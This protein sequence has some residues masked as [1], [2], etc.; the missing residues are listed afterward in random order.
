MRSHP[1]PIILLLLLFASCGRIIAQGR[2]LTPDRVN[3]RVQAAAVEILINGRLSGS[4]AVIDRSGIVVTAA[5]VVANPNARIEI[6][7]PDNQKLTAKIH[8]K[9]AGHDVI[10][11]TLPKQSGGYVALQPA[12]RTVTVGSK[13]FMVA[14]PLFRHRQLFTGT[15]TQA[16]ASAEFL[17]PQ[18]VEVFYIQT[19]SPHGTSGAAWVNSQGQYIG[20]QSAMLWVKNAPQG[21][22]FAA[23]LSAIEDLLENPRIVG[24][25]SAGFAVEELWEQSPEFLATVPPELSG[26]VIRFL[27]K[28]SPF[29]QAKIPTGTI[30]THI[31]TKALNTRD[32]FVKQIRSR[33]IDD[34][35]QFTIR[36]ADG[37]N[38]RIVEMKLGKLQ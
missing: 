33:K 7:F 19:A 31:D 15:V 4:G 12:R 9:D 16:H 11:L 2:E 22:A 29:E 3:S 24:T 6:L 23:P 17:N 1:R 28:G 20:I 14:S 35:I 25:P 30:I 37:T 26:L 38:E 34:T 36:D 18:Y 10:L 13:V 8:A 5:H 21:I 32:E 27:L